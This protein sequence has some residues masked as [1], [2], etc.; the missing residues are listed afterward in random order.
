MYQRIEINHMV[1]KC[2]ENNRPFPKM[3]KDV[4]VKKCWAEKCFGK[5]I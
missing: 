3:E 2:L 1:K 5:K 4:K